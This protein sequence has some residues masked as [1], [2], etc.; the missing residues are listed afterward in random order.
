MAVLLTVWL[1]RGFRPALTAFSLQSA[2]VSG[3]EA[4]GHDKTQKRREGGTLRR[5]SN[6][7]VQKDS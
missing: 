5:V 3:S 7:F 4:A 2:R 1:D 6:S